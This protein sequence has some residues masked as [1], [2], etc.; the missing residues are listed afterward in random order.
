MVESISTKDKKVQF[1]FVAAVPVEKDL[2]KFE[3]GIGPLDFEGLR[4]ISYPGGQQYGSI[5]PCEMNEFSDECEAWEK[6]NGPYEKQAY[7]VSYETGSVCLIF[8]NVASD[9]VS[10]NAYGTGQE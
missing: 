1:E 4:V 10:A 2:S 3:N 7:M 6:E 5:N 8:G 9:M